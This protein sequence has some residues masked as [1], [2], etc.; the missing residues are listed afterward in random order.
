MKK[1]KE[2]K[3]LLST[4]P[5]LAAWL[6]AAAVFFI[7]LSFSIITY[8]TVTIKN[9]FFLLFFFLLFALWAAFKSSAARAF[10]KKRFIYFLPLI[11]YVLY[12][13]ISFLFNPYKLNSFEDFFYYTAVYTIPLLLVPLQRYASVRVINNFFFLTCFICYAYGAVQIIDIWVLKGADIMPWAEFFG[14]RIFSTQA[15]PNFFADFLAFS[16][17]W[18]FVNF[19]ERKE[20]RFLVLFVL[21]VVDLYFTESKGA[22]LAF[23]AGVFILCLFYTN[24]FVPALSKKEKTFIN[25][26]GA[27]MVCAVIILTAVFSV[28]RM[29]SVNLRVETWK[30]IVNMVSSRPVF[31]YGAGAFKTVYPEFRK[32]EIF[33]IEKIHNNETMHAENEYLE[34]LANGGVIG[35]ALFIFVIVYIIT[36]AIKKVRFL[37]SSGGPAPPQAYALLSFLCAFIVILIHSFVDISL[38]L[39]STSFFYA[40]FMALIL[41]L[42]RPAYNDYEVKAVNKT[43]L[44]SAV[45]SVVFF[46]AYA[47]A[48]W[49]V[50]IIYCSMGS[51]AENSGLGRSAVWFL[52]WGVLFITAL[53]AMGI[54]YKTLSSSGYKATFSM[55]IF[56]PLIFAPCYLFMADKDASVAHYYFRN[57]NFDGVV[58]ASTESIKYNPFNL[59][60]RRL[61][62]RGFSERWLKTKTNEPRS[63]DKK[64]EYLSDFER[65]AKDFE[66]L[67]KHSPNEALLHQDFGSLLYKR[68]VE[69]FREG[70]D[71]GAYELLSKAE[72]Q[73]KKSLLLDPVLD[74]TYMSLANIEI[75]RRNPK[76]ALVWLEEY[77]KG[78]QGVT[79]KEYLD[80]NKNNPAVLDAVKLVERQL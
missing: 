49:F 80:I 35:F 57:A 27:L 16:L 32:P 78:P 68:A 30:G 34:V 10:D 37:T 79:N 18:V 43:K 13:I 31:G 1:S 66:Y 58:S 46:A 38:R 71:A 70:D 44:L 74:A 76:G 17:F 2:P 29:Q 4:L 19:L 54:F 53:G 11:I 23:G 20:K 12:N 65:A 45:R 28:K 42:V 39:V 9:V 73:F 48:V 15:N 24:F 5:P 62:A 55:L 63:G 36:L 22:W 51:L 69:L 64:G 7:T 41:F 14:K 40:L 8:N 50:Y 60:I 61:R 3:I 6:S 21:G 56:I 77:L 26:L 25:T 47:G 75:L 33:Y 72:M 59:A 67:E 52:M